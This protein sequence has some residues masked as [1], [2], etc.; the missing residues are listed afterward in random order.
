MRLPLLFTLI[1]L[2]I[3]LL[4]D[5]YIYFRVPRQIKIRGCVLRSRRWYLYSAIFTNLLL[6]A[7]ICAPKR[8]GETSLLPI[9]WM[10][11]TWAT[12]YFSKIFYIIFSLLGRIPTLFKR[13]T[14]PLGKY[15]GFPI[16]LI[17]FFT[18][19]WGALIG[20]QKIMVSEVEIISAKV[21]PAFDGFRIV[22]FSD[23]HVGTWGENPEFLS[24]LVDHINALK[25][26]LVVFTGDLVNRRAREAEPFVDVLS[27]IKSKYGVYSIMGNH[28][29]GDY[30]DWPNEA[31][32]RA[33]ANELRGLQ[34]K[35]GWKMLDNTHTFIYVGG[36]S[37]AL[38]G[39]ENW[40]EPPFKQY[41]DLSRAYP[42]D[43]QGRIEDNVFKVL[44]TH[45]PVHW[46][47]HVRYNTDIDLTLSGHTHAMQFMIGAPGTGFSPS[48]WKYPEWGG[49]YEYKGDDGIARYLYVNIGCGE[50]GIPARVGATPEI[51]LITLHRPH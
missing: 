2:V 5:L 37:I 26:D 31:A 18:M 35:M 24:R 43:A 20:R 40:G 50:V 38:I 7:C 34:E 36:D 41:G 13:K 25:P 10:L 46:H 17:C 47:E 16:A 1:L 14:W 23:A 3:S 11:Y 19:W 44:L 21:P 33:D 8:D 42:H 27:G 15:I 9:M 30:A 48:A 4:S 22:Q 45:N 28:D 29:Y 12:I 6:V 49:L 51:T 39:V 32:H